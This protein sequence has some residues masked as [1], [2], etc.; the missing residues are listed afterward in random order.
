[1]INRRLFHFCLIKKCARKANGG[2]RRR[3]TARVNS[4]QRL[5]FS[6]ALSGFSVGCAYAASSYRLTN[7][8][9]QD[10]TEF[11]TCKHVTN[12]H[13]SGQDIFIPTNT[14][15]EWAQFYD[16][17][18]SGVTVS[19]C[20]TVVFFATTGAQSWS[21]PAGV[22]TI[23]AECISGGDGGTG[24]TSFAGSFAGWGGSYA[25]TNAITV[26]P[27]QTIYLSIGVGGTAGAAGGGSGGYG[28]NSWVNVSANNS[29]TTTAQGV[30]AAS[31]GGSAQN[32]GNT[33]QFVSTPG[34]GFSN[35]G[36]GAGG[37][38]GPTGAGV[39]GSAPSGNNAARGAANGGSPAGGSG[40][41]SGVAGGNGSA[42]TVWTQTSNNA[43]AGSGSGGGGGGSGKAG[44]NG[45]NYG[46][47]GGGG[48]KA[49]SGN[50]GGT[51]GQGICVIT[52]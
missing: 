16:H 6:L 27:T 35:G 50:A 7:S 43:T 5:L 22:T 3:Y 38:A 20:T 52:Y 10:V 48:G 18:P 41:A 15:A 28:G 40:G 51:G 11:S 14:S 24:G 25:K 19:A 26:T 8:I 21:I 12:S 4:A 47:G 46:G 42:T 1:M 17:P 2:G 29:P 9:S 34:L 13:G 49:A 30:C 37:A 31:Y 33:T 45:A 36:N 39:S 44:G 32:L 23:K